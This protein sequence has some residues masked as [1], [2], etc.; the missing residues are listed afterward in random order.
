M[1]LDSRND[2]LNEKLDATDLPNAVHVLVKDAHKR[3]RQLRLLAISITLD[4]ILTGGLAYLSLQTHSIAKQAESNRAAIIRNCET[5]NDGRAKN[6][7]LW[8]FAFNLPPATT[9]TE[10]QKSNLEKFKAKVDDTFMLRDCSKAVEK[11]L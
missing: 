10:Q 3:K 5:S 8:D 7:E 2:Q 9:Q 1:S 6:K 4:L 11:E